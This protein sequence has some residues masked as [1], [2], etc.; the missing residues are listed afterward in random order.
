M[1]KNFAASEKTAGDDVPAAWA[2]IDWA[3][4][5]HVVALQCAGN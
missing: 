4:Q 2:G 5:K 1:D 3:D